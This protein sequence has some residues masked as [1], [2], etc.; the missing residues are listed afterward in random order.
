MEMEMK[1]ENMN[2]L[3]K[4]FYC[5]LTPRKTLQSGKRYHKRC[6]TGVN[7]DN[8]VNVDNPIESRNVIR[9]TQYSDFFV[10]DKL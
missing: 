8:L 10:C 3:S 2:I 6:S 4:L 5:L 9:H 7:L 1:E